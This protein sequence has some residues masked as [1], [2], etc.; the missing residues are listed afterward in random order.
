MI[1]FMTSA[2]TITAMELIG[3]KKWY[4]WAVGLVNQIFW[5]VL[6]YQKEMKW[7]F[8]VVAVLTWRYSSALLRWKKA[9]S[10]VSP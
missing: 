5:A 7:M 1:D 8:V 10:Q 9:A 4:G 2:L 3:R 6:C